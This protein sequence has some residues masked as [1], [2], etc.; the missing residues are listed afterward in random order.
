MTVVTI[1]V[2]DEHELM[3]LITSLLNCTS[4]D[5][6][7]FD[8]TVVVSKARKRSP[9]PDGSSLVSCETENDKHAAS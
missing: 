9:L 2:G 4:R 7:G 8:N 3:T 5:F 1:S 6:D